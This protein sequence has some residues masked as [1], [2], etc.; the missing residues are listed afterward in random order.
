M[1][2]RHCIITVYRHQL[3]SEA[4]PRPSP[5]E[6]EPSGSPSGR[7]T[8]PPA[9]APSSHQ[10]PISATLVD[11]HWPY[12][13]YNVQ[14][15][16][17][18]TSLSSYFSSE[19]H[20]SPVLLITSYDV[21]RSE[22]AA[23][24]ISP[25]RADAESAEDLARYLQGVLPHLRYTSCGRG[26]ELAGLMGEEN[27]RPVSGVSPGQQEGEEGEDHF[28]EEGGAG[29]GG[30]PAFGGSAPAV[31]PPFPLLYSGFRELRPTSSKL[32]YFY[33]LVYESDLE[34]WLVRLFDPGSGRLHSLPIH[35]GDLSKLSLN[36]E[37]DED[38][39]LD[40][41]GTCVTS[42][43]KE[44]LPLLKNLLL[45]LDYNG[46]R[47]KLLPFFTGRTI[48][49]ME[50]LQWRV[51]VNYGARFGKRYVLLRGAV[52]L[53]QDL[54]AVILYDPLSS[55]TSVGDE[56]AGRVFSIGGGGVERESG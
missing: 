46:E 56:E 24:E 27:G 43:R 8:P 29:G 50:S 19:G 1:N 12:A 4:S 45:R 44:A 53:E 37:N 16:K 32:G 42:P 40:L 20:K 17:N 10:G 11:L 51:V 25:A 2:G 54:F 21:G 31:R 36:I 30:R 38:R 3:G 5:A 47:L 35:K 7:T 23:L 41:W 28:R 15:Q 49:R 26:L 33:L 34:S 14:Q 6:G 22:F 9:A 52:S 55:R 39:D 13:P 18:S 48:D